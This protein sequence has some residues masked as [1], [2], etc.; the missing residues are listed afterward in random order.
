MQPL[1]EA[2]DHVRGGRP[3]PAIVVYAQS[4]ATNREA[5]TRRFP[6]ALFI[7]AELLCTG[8]LVAAAIIWM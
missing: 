8:A 4:Q 1:D 3:G 5:T 6:L 7:V 2:V